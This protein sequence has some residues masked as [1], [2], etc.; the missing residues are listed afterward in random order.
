MNKINKNLVSQ[1]KSVFA[2]FKN[3]NT[4]KKNFCDD[5]SRRCKINWLLLSLHIFELEA[6]RYFR[7]FHLQKIFSLWFMSC[8]QIT[9]LFFVLFTL[10]EIQCCKRNFIALD[11][12]IESVKNL[13][14]FLK[15][16][17]CNQPKLLI[18]Y[19]DLRQSLW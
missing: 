2:V 17:N 12:V 5:G 18:W 7:N 1:C 10:S 8:W 3:K 13:F 9:M 19:Q 4:K 11:I 6:F 14:L 16:I 15:D